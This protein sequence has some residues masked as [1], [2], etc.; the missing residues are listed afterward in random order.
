MLLLK[1]AETGLVQ[2]SKK[3]SSRSHG[4]LV[5]GWAAWTSL[6][7]VAGD[8]LIIMIVTGTQGQ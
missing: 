4:M 5:E 2:T 7:I 3:E 1:K 8:E 6:C